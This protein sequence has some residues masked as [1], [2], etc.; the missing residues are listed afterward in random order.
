MSFLITPTLPFIPFISFP[1]T[2]F[3]QAIPTDALSSQLP[4]ITLI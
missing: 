2:I 4:F 3:A 1:I